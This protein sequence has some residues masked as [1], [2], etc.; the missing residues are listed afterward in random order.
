M[1]FRRQIARIRRHKVQ[2]EPRPNI[3]NT[4]RLL[5]INHRSIPQIHTSGIGCRKNLSPVSAALHRLL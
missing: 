1:T 3:P 5:K 2:K 4:A